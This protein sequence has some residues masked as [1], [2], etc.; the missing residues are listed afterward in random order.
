MERL[1]KHS[2]RQ[3]D[4]ENERDEDRRGEMGR[5]RERDGERWS[6]NFN[7]TTKDTVMPL[8]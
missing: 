6:T 5:D 4:R 7:L 3:A 2:E 8:F 1:G